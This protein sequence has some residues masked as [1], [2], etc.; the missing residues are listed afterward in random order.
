MRSTVARSLGGPARRWFLW[1][2]LS[3]LCMGPTEAYAQVTQGSAAS[4]D[5]SAPE[6]SVPVTLGVDQLDGALDLGLGTLLQQGVLSDALQ[7]GLPVRI[8]VVAELWRD[9]FFDAQEGLDEW[10]ATLVF[11]PLERRYR[12]GTS[13]E[14]EAQAGE[15]AVEYLSDAQT[16]LEGRFVLGLRPRSSGTFYYTAV[17]EVE[18]LSLSDLDEL[19]RWLS[20]DPDPS[21]GETEDEDGA[22]GRGIRRLMVRMLGLPKRR[23]RESTEEFVFDPAVGVIGS[24]N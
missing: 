7:S 21:A 13:S 24:A 18:T 14:G 11:D 1:T 4:G 3:A 16:A 20:G 2:A 17:I 8:R 5:E 22:V 9:R 10:R 23:L 12:F 19:Q 6:T 15:L